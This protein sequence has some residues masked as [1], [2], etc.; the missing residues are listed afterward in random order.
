M[1][2]RRLY[3]LGGLIVGGITVLMLYTQEQ[4]RKSELQAMLNAR[5]MRNIVVAKKSIPKGTI[6][7]ADVVGY[8]K[9]HQQRVETGAVE[10]HEVVLGK[11]TVVPL[12]KGQQFT[13][14]KLTDVVQTLS[15]RLP[16][17]KRAVTVSID[18]VS[19]VNGMVAPGDF[20]DIIGSMPYPFQQSGKKDTPTIVTLFQQVLVLAIDQLSTREEMMLARDEEQSKVSSSAIPAFASITFA[21]SEED[22]KL[23]MFALE[24]GKIRLLLRAPGEKASGS[25][26]VITMD[27]AWEKI[28]SI[29][30]VAPSSAPQ[31]EVFRG[32]DRKLEALDEAK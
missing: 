1:D 14:S 3:L 19:S 32:I 31:V 27:K 6:L 4:K 18:K 8:M 23:L 20:V 9:I 25:K 21:L 30:K 24:V 11:M 15:N 28:F 5:A 12:N 22:A 16:A 29:K 13:L 26:E 7:T 2:K 17:G 10:S